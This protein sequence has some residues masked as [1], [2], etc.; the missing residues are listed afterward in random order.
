MR[1][2]RQVLRLAF[3]AGA[4]RRRIARSLGLSRDVVTDY[5]TRATATGLNWP[6]PPDL[7]DA[8]LED[9]LF[10]PMSVNALRKPEPAW[11]V[12][13]HEMKRKGATLQVLHEEFL[14]EQ[15]SGIGYSLFCDRY[16]EWQQGLKRYMR[17]THVAGERVFVDYA[18]STVVILDP[19]T[20]EVRKAQIFV[21]ILGASNYT[22]AE[23][24]W[25]Q[26]LPDWIAAHTRMFEFF[27][28]VPQAVVCDNL[29]SAVTK[30]S[31]TEPKVHPAYLHLAEHYNTLILPARPRKPKDKAKA[32]NAVLIVE[33][34]IL[35]R[36]RKRVFTNLL[37]LNE[38]ICELLND[39]NERKFQKL[40]GSRRTQFEALDQPELTALPTQAFEYTE[41]RKVRIGLDGCFDVDG[42]IYSAPFTLC[43]QSIE[44]RITSATIEILHRG[45][46]VA[47]HARSGG[48]VPV[49]DPQHLQ[50]AD[51]YFGLWSADHELVWATTIGPNTRAF[52]QILLSTTKLKEQGYRSAGALKR[53]EKEFGAERLEAGCTRAID[54]G[55]NS[56]SSVRSILRTGLDQQQAP[57]DDFQEASFHHP[58]VRGSDY[59]H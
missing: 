43:K 57:D 31:R 15:P 37:E 50:P 25:S 47:S 48:V 46:R 30:A 41:F 8:Q 38:A 51:R 2:I 53:M 23:A 12:I 4:S 7:D 32:E 14:A 27:G 20:G 54:I 34:W 26:Q 10:P 49:I 55:A 40:P 21:G 6:L 36:L 3:E 59:Y 22:Y 18:G 28:G 19:E 1:K 13:H 39:L 52:L 33:R 45:R 44:L 9:R 11:A 16:R 24:H 29:K 17:Q 35:F 58:N 42:C 5:L 56:L